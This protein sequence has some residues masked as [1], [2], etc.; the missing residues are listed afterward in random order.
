MDTERPPA[1]TA[2][3]SH[4]VRA[5]GID[6]R[7]EEQGGGE[8]AA[9]VVLLHG[10][11][12]GPTLWRHVVPRLAGPKLRCLAFEL[13][14]FGWSMEA[15][16]GRDIS[17]ARQA[18]HLRAWLDA[19]AIER[20]V[21]VGHD[22]GGGVAQRFAVAHPERC[23]GLVLADCIAYD[24]WP[25]APVRAARA[26]AE[27]IERLPPA[28]LQPVLLGGLF[29]LGHDSGP[30]R[31]QSSRLHGAPY[32]R[33]IGPR[34]FAHQLRSLDVNDTMA[35][36]G[37][38]PELRLPA[39]IVWGEA[40]PLGMVSAERLAAD[41]GAPLHRLARARHFTPE[42][43]PDAVAAAVGLVLNRALAGTSA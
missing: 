2:G 21:L 17:V 7:W 25:V 41:L 39:A 35:I 33:P 9:T 27:A 5:D 19:L 36:A 12:T 3:T 4:T 43:H 29:Y 10:I 20:A 8:D 6:M 18:D 16:L 34:A 24:N 26:M 31:A 32:A 37:N 42:D 15:G 40:D 1:T 13:V 23:R 22:L 14:G 28:L 30:T 38:L 11:P